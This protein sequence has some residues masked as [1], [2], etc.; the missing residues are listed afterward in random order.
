MGIDIFPGVT[1]KVKIASTP[2]PTISSLKPSS[3]SPKQATSSYLNNSPSSAVPSVQPPKSPSQ[4]KPSSS[5]KLSTKQSSVQSSNSGLLSKQNIAY[6][7]TSLYKR[8]KFLK[9]AG[10]SSLVLATGTLT[11]NTYKWLNPILVSSPN[12]K[13]SRYETINEAIK[14]AEPNSIIQI[15]PGIYREGLI[16]DKPVEII[17]D[18]LREKI[19]I[20]SADSDCILMQ[21]DS[22]V[23]RG[24]TLKCKTGINGQKFYGIDI[25]QGKLIV[26]DCDI[27][28]DSLSCIAI[29]NSEANP[30]IRKC[31]IYDSKHSGIYIHENGKGTIED[32]DIYENALAGVEIETS[33]D[34]VIRKCRINRNIY[35]AV[36]VYKNGRGT[37]TDC[38]L[39]NNTK[40]DF[41][42]DSSSWVRGSNNLS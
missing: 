25:P 42:I 17:G 40:G 37:I 18:G 29:H 9:I 28:S 32:C 24:L 26:E 34:P 22:A 14:N 2:T 7:K 33:A 30:V 3:Q 1:N 5:K 15:P 20:E 19:I 31:R 21:T 23:V 38:D 11:Y 35:Q 39:R 10:V 4:L 6:I 16:I 8:R 12:K 41:Y 13:K 36:Y 27:T